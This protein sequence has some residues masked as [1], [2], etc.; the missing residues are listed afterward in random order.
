[1]P[2]PAAIA[3]FGTQ[4]IALALLLVL[5]A[6][7]WH[8]NIDWLYYPTFA[9]VYAI[10]ILPIL[11]YMFASAPLRG[12]PRAPARTRFLCLVPAYNE[13]RVI[14]NPVRSLMAQEYP[15]E[16]YEV[17]VVFDGT[18]RTNEVAAAMG[19][20]VVITPTNGYG[21]HR[22]LDYALR[23]LL[24]EDDDRYVAVF[25]A[26]NIVSPNYLSAMN[27]AIV[28]S[29]HACLQSF[30][31][32][33]NGGANWVT[34]ALWAACVSSSRLY[35]TG[36]ARLLRNVLICGTGWCC[37]ADLLRRY[38]PRIRTQTEDI[39]LNGILALEERVRVAY[40]PSASIYD[41]KPLSLW[42][43]IRQ[44]M[45]WMCG[46][47]RVAYYYFWRCLSQGLLRGDAALL[48]LAAYYLVPFALLV[49]FATW[50]LLAGLAIG[51][52]RITGP[53]ASGPLNLAFEVISLFFMFGYQIVGFAGTPELTGTPW[54]RV[55]RT[56]LYAFYS[57]PFA[58]VVWPAAL[59]WALF[60]VGRDDWLY[61]T[62]HVSAADEREA[63]AMRAAS[64]AARSSGV[65][66][67][68]LTLQG[69]TL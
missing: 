27:D 26:D 4:A 28:A 48:E 39:E 59:V 44:R 32:V 14:G 20:R 57:L 60:R 30:H 18:D 46:H 54:V 13:E 31:N 23:T 61:H 7:H 5:R 37:R 40:V 38:W 9:F 6:G 42:V 1:M 62:P 64:V 19:A 67:I 45:R 33:L 16:L 69:G 49:S 68:P 55:R 66:D 65:A 36:R 50:P 51:A 29:G 12:Y 43:A 63:A 34:K 52:M 47:T 53:L 17:V 56:I 15:R 10:W 2:A 11:G 24:A 41:E 35:L 8:P 58:L 25:D 22:A 21:K 3:I